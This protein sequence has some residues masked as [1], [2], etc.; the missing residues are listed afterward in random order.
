MTFLH[1]T[2]LP[3]A[4]LAVVPILLHL[5]T[6][7]RLRTVELSTY[8]FLF[9][10]YVQQRRQMK[11]LE[12]LL[13]ALRA[14]FLLALVLV[15]CR[16]VIKHWD[17]LFGGGAGREVVMLVDASASMNART[18]G[19]SS[20][21]RARKAALAVAGQMGK[22]DRLTLVKVGARPVEV[23]SRFNSDADTIREKIEGLEAGPSRA[24][25]FAAFSYVFGPGRQPRDSSPAVYLFTDGQASSW[26]EVRDQGLAR[27][28][29][30]GTK[31]TV[32]HVGSDDPPGNRGVVGDA[33]R[34]KLAVLG[35]PVRL[36][37]RV[38][39]HSKTEP[40][41]VTVG[42]FLD[43]KEVA[44]VPLTL[45][46][47]ETAT[48]E[49]IYTPTEPGALRGRFEIAGDRFPDDDTFLFTLP[50]AEQVRVLLVN[51][52]PAADPFENEALYLRTALT[53]AAEDEHAATAAA[54]KKLGP[55]QEFVKS[56]DVR[57]V[58]E[59]KVNAEILRDA[60]VAILANCGGLNDAQYK[61][62]RDFVAAGGGL[63]VFPGDKVNP[64][65]YNKQFFP[66]PGPQKEA[67][68]A[69]T[70]GPAEGDPT[71][72]EA[73]ER[74]AS[75]DYAHPALSVFDEPDAHYLTTA[76]FT[77]RYPIK[78]TGPHGATWPLAK[79]GTGA[80]ALVE[81]RLGDGV[82]MLAAF[83]ATVKWTNLPLKPEFVPLVLRMV[84]YVTHAPDLGVPSTVPADGAAEISV[85]G[86]WAPA[87]GKVT[88]SKNRVSSGP[89]RAVGV[90][91][92]RPV[93]PDGR[94]RAIVGVEVRGGRLDPPQLASSSFA[95]NVAP[96]ESRFETVKEEQVREWLPKSG[97]SFVSAS[98]EAQQVHG[99]IG[100]EREV[101]RPL[102]FVLFAIIGAEVLPG[103]DQAAR[104]PST[105]ASP[106]RSPAGCRRRQEELG[107]DD[108]EEDEDRGARPPLLADRAVDLLRL[109][110][111]ARD[112]GAKPFMVFFHRFEVR[113]S[114]AV[115]GHEQAEESNFETV[116]EEQV[117]E[118]L[119]MPDLSF[120]SASSEAQQVHGSIGEERE[121]WRPL[122][123][124]LFAIIGAEFFLAASRTRPATERGSPPTV[125]RPLI[126]AR[127]N[128]APMIAK[129]TKI[130]G[131]QTSAPR[132][133]SRGPAAPRLRASP[134][135]RPSAATR[136]PGLLS[137][138]RSSSWRR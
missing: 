104:G 47:G 33:P 123:F 83:P 25:L 12:A 38:V 6:L 14:L 76:I 7:H 15:F 35:L 37:P 2:L 132:R 57:E 118:W 119:P 103:D 135:V 120:V 5:L 20:M 85:A 74:L 110:R 52:H 10:S 3:L 122:I 56:L 28:I 67:L 46:P 40:A 45:K 26:R 50:V 133:S 107:A 1:W 53:A 78:L 130:K 55:S 90:A 61:A 72:R 48:K 115:T 23:F 16:P 64:D 121:V 18:A 69:A 9:D 129:R 82:V 128:S 58:T 97:L 27:I 54:P 17:R 105:A 31:I 91:A 63:L 106:D 125:P 137:P 49:V 99:S 94:P 21:D 79:F 126:V 101:W 11:F 131:R 43:D 112:L 34:Q 24:N 77:R 87:S 108:R 88:D 134:Q 36:R 114:G 80:P 117:R 66:V 68:T 30:E 124:V 92:P 111:G 8:R 29:P 39:N 136:G 100:E 89:V 102:I 75:V 32:V 84:S 70:L 73:P 19:Q 65:A 4:A 138:F 71:K 109:G 51:G 22:D 59:D 81:S 93:R 13:A 95:V 60:E 41:E 86:T 42:V 96:E 116:K 44:R 113:S 127:K 98:S 62:V